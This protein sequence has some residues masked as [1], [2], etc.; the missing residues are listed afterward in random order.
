MGDKKGGQR[1]GYE[2]SP[3][4]A[5]L[6]AGSAMLRA[7]PRGRRRNRNPLACERMRSR[8][9]R[10]CGGVLAA[11]DAART[12]VES[13]LGGVSDPLCHPPK[14]APDAM[15]HMCAMRLAAAS[16][17]PRWSATTTRL[18]HRGSAIDGTP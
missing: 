11:A 6:D 7:P 14:A 10:E 12:M 4:A 15:G 5:E 17:T 8:G 16:A 13:E 9:H 1:V 2:L 3:S 18:V